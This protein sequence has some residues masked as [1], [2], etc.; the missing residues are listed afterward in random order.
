MHLLFSSPSLTPPPP[1]SPSVVRFFCPGSPE[2]SHPRLVC[3]HGWAMLARELQM[4]A[5]SLVVSL[6]AGSVPAADTLI[7]SVG[8]ISLWGVPVPSSWGRRPMMQTRV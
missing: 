4:S 1:A 7:F 5:L 3:F 6:A 2:M 8:R